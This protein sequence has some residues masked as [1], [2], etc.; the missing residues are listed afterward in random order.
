VRVTSAEAVPATLQ[1]EHALAQFVAEHYQRLFRLAMLVCRD[2]SDASD[3]VQ[4]GLE[5]A[6][7]QRGALRDDSSM[8]SWLDRIVVNESIRHT[9]RRSSWLNRLM[10]AAGPRWIDPIDERTAQGDAWV[11]LRE[12]YDRLSPEQRAVIA[13]HLHAGYSITETAELVGAPI[14]TV[15]SRLRLAKDRLRREM[16]EGS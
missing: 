12:A 3:A 5:R 9:R 10:P 13:L 16:G 14:E 6:W 4:L 2:P 15:R 1:R 11:S 8:R 7:R